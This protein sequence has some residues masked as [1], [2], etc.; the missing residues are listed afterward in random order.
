MSASTA[1]LGRHL[2]FDDYATCAAWSPDG[3]RVAAGALSGELA[4]I[5]LAEGTSEQ[6][7]TH[8]MGTLA[9]GWSSNGLLASGGQDGVVRIWSPATGPVGQ[10]A[11]TG[12]CNALA[13]SPSDEVLAVAVGS[14]VGLVRVEPGSE[15]VGEWH[16]GMP[17]TVASLTWTPNGRWVGAGCYGGV[18]WFEPGTAEEVKVLERKGSVLSIAVSS[19][20]KWLAAGNQDAEVRVWRLWSGE[21]LR[22][23]GFT[24]KITLLGFHPSS[25]WLSVADG[26]AVASWPFRG[27]GPAGTS[28][29]VIDAHDG[30]VTALAHRSSDGLLVTGAGDG[31]L[32]AWPR[33]DARRPQWSV[34]TDAE[35]A[36]L[37]WNP[38]GTSIA[39]ATAAGN[40]LTVTPP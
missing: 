15:P 12:W 24:G 2:A 30:R 39:V 14:S 20:G 31:T 8:E 4:V 27:K 23:S 17:S 7:P 37:A 34:D 38:A 32:R 1:E 19:D 21:D 13:W 29:E 33:P 16:H 40:L 10:L 28:A 11:A 36:A 25:K 6:L 9:V 35:V 5:D 3:R 26:T 18:R 22:M